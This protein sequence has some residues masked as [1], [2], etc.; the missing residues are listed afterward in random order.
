MLHLLSGCDEIWH[1][2]DIGSCALT[3]RLLKIK[4]V[5]AVYGN[6]DGSDLRLQFPLVDVFYCESVKVMMVHIGGYPGHYDRKIVP[7][8]Q[9]EKPN[10]LITGHSHI[11]RVMYD[12][13]GGWLFMN[14]GAAGKQGF[15]PVR[16]LLR[17][18]IEGER[19]FDLEAIELG[20]RGSLEGEEG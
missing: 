14:P 20:K 1:A 12:Q 10:L 18:S 7:L 6:A 19:I 4:P 3:D 17:F 2:G 5:H 8:L 16:T 15:H 11:L 13:K 9:M